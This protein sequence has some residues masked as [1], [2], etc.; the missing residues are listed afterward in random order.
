MGAMLEL[1]WL[2]LQTGLGQLARAWA[3]A[4]FVL[5]GTASP[6]VPARCTPIATVA[7]VAVWK[8]EG[9]LSAVVFRSG[10]AVDVDGAPK[11]YHANDTDALN[12]M[13]HAGRP[14]HWWALATQHGA[15]VVQGP[16]HP[17]PG[18]YLSMTSLQNPAFAVT[19]PRRYVDASTIPYVAL[20]EAVTRAGR[21]RLGDLAAVVNQSN[22]KV[23]FAIYADQGPRDKLGEGSLYLVNQLRNAPVPDKA[24]IRQS[25]PKGIVYVLFPG[26]GNRRPKSR[27]QIVAGAAALFE[28][29]GG[30]A[31]A[32][33]CLSQ[34]KRK[35][36]AKN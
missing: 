1:G 3:V 30:V 7:D 4:G 17:A 10:M 5:A 14:G 12:R 32:K 11:A 34:T 15:P 28:R 9:P 23:A 36:D 33:V 6:Q 22:G 24:G 13:A 31:A 25:L 16:E 18:Y 27:E 8:H 19:D 20:P 35:E 2:L 21:V 26:S 29:W